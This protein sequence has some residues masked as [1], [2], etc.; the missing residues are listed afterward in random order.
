MTESVTE[1]QQRET[2]HDVFLMADMKNNIKKGKFYLQTNP[3]SALVH[4]F[5]LIHFNNW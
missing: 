2:P 4:E 1:A 5:C 3:L